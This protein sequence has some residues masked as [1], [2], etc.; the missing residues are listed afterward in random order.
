MPSRADALTAPKKHLGRA[1]LQ[2]SS[3]SR[4]N[5]KLITTMRKLWERG[6]NCALQSTSAFSPNIRPRSILLV[7]WSV[8]LSVHTCFGRP[9]AL[10]NAWKSA[11]SDRV[12]LTACLREEADDLDLLDEE[13]TDVAS[14]PPEVS[15]PAILSSSSVTRE[16]KYSFGKTSLLLKFTCEPDG[17]GEL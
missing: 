4:V 11:L 16:P 3:L 14:S 13:T 12:R 9:C 17:G 15:S 5:E 1:T 8:G 6:T 10:L 2:Q 7:L